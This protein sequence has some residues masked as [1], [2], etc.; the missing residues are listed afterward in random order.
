MANA[1]VEVHHVIAEFVRSL[2]EA[3]EFLGAVLIGFGVLL[4]FCL[5]LRLLLTAR[6]KTAREMHQAYQEVR[7]KLSRYLAL[8]LE[9][10]LAADLLGTSVNPSWDQLGRL[11]VIATLRTSLNYFLAREFDEAERAR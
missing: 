6:E 2:Q 8:A 7:L 10:Q 11:G 5:L 1:D 9:F 3:T 4:A